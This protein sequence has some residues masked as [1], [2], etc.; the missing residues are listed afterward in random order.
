MDTPDKRPTQG[1]D[2]RKIK[3]ELA[4]GPQ[5]AVGLEQTQIN[6]FHT[7]GGTGFAAE[8]A[9]ALGD[10]FSGR[11]VEY[12]GR[13]CS[14]NGPDRIVDG[15]RIQT[16]YYESAT[17]TMRS[18]FDSEGVYRY[19]G[20][21]LEVPADQYEAC[22]AKMRTKIADGK[23]PGVSNP[24]D[25]ESIIHKGRVTY[26]QA[27][28]IARAGTIDGLKYDAKTHAVGAGLACGVSFAINFAQLKWNGVDTQAALKEAALNG[29][30]TG[31][32]SF[33]AGIATSQV[34]RTKA[35]AIG[36]VAARDG[37]RS[38][39]GTRA[40]KLVIEKI[41]AASL[42]RSVHGAAAT[43][44]VAKLVRS[45]VVTSVVVTAVIATPD[46]YRATFSKRISWKQF[47][48]NL[49]VNATGVAGGA[50][51]WFTGAAAGAALGSVVPIL[52]T[53]V[54]GIAGGIVG[55]LTGGTLAA[56]GSKKALDRFVDD[57]AV[58]LYPVIQEQL[59]QLASDYMLDR[60]E[61][62]AL[63][64]QVEKTIRPGFLRDLY[65]SK[66]RPGF[67]EAAF[68]PVCQALVK[69]RA[70]VALPDASALDIAVAQALEDA[71]QSA[72]T[73]GEASGQAPA[74]ADLAE[75]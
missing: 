5:I 63:I 14:L 40:G 48:K 4:V 54:G 20:Q 46:L 51:G 50:G 66:D 8:D 67:L 65:A 25:A 61:V 18:A 35:A 42:G 29:L 28:N 2:D 62:D 38:V 23:V 31:T 32:L 24:A 74:V 69:Q 12:A 19:A 53:A 30:G 36:V 56:M 21:R 26:R 27:R 73:G 13:D 70:P 3:P 58:A 17:E 7:K 33:T 15:I 64:Q 44:H 52:G 1:T 11:K 34:L 45:N 59:S 22:V 72:Q 55:S 37:V 60:Q 47:G 43:N 39:Q 49:T 9:N 16:K 71:L 41:A 10:A 68:E 57:D 75:S 6:K